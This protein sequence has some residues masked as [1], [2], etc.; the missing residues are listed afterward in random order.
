MYRALSSTSSS[1]E[2]IQLPYVTVAAEGN[3]LDVMPWLAH[4]TILFHDVTTKLTNQFRW[5]CLTQ[6]PFSS[7]L[8]PSDL[9]FFWTTKEVLQSKTHMM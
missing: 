2:Y 8:V 5:E 1:S 6:P 4:E 9:H 7:D 3:H